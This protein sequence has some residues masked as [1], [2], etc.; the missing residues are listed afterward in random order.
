MGHIDLPDLMQ[1]TSSEGVW[2]ELLGLGLDLLYNK[3]IMMILNYLYYYYYP[4][5]VNIAC[6]PPTMV[7]EMA[8]IVDGGGPKHT[9]RILTY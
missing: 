3:K 9:N 5:L 1:G 7:T 8:S 6:P 4:C 2:Q